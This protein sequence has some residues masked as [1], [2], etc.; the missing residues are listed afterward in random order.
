MLKNTFQQGRSEHRD[1]AYPAGTVESLGDART[2]L[3]GF[4]SIWLETI[5]V[6]HIP[7]IKDGAP[8]QQP[9]S[10]ESTPRSL[11]Q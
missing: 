9:G 11:R 3:E 7:Y 4:F 5:Q 8:A 6:D 2:K 1:E 10:P